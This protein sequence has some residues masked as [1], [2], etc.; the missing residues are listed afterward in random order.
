MFVLLSISLSLILQSLEFTHSVM[1]SCGHWCPCLC[2]QDPWHLSRRSYAIGLQT[3][4][5]PLLIIQQPSLILSTRPAS[6]SFR[7]TQITS[8][9]VYWCDHLFIVHF[10]LRCV[11]PCEA[12]QSH[13]LVI[14]LLFT[15]TY[16]YTSSCDSSGIV[17][18]LACVPG[19]FKGTLT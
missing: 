19:W 2:C 1:L 14:Y 3:R 12:A 10:F 6:Y 11:L 18:I 9:L 16:T 15:N 17:H 4:D 5:S 8:S 7:L 13:R